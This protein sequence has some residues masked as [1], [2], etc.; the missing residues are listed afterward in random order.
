[1]ASMFCGQAKWERGLFATS[2]HISSHG[3]EMHTFARTPEELTGQ[4][5][6]YHRNADAIDDANV[7]AWSKARTRSRS[8][9]R[10]IS[11][12]DEGDVG[13]EG[14][15]RS[16]APGRS[17]GPERI[18][19]GRDG[20]WPAVRGGG[21]GDAAGQVIRH[22]V[23]HRMSGTGARWAVWL[24]ARPAL[25]TIRPALRRNSPR[26]VGRASGWARQRAE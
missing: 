11:R 12:R 18:G 16:G 10:D 17:G 5:S 20:G 22:V 1:M 13:Q 8:P 2:L 26:C 21:S 15:G 4:P 24:S 25:C 3:H 9:A 14:L 7:A 19:P 23:A 6:V